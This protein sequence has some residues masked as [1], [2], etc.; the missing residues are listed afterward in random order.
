ME[1]SFEANTDYKSKCF[2]KACLV[3]LGAELNVDYMISGSFD[4]LGRKIVITLKLID[5]KNNVVAKSA[6]HEFNYQENEL[7]RM[8]EIIIR[9][10]HGLEVQK[11]LYE[12][13]NFKNEL[14]TSTNL[15]KVN[16][17]V[18]RV[19]YGIFVRALEEFAARLENH[20]GMDI[21]P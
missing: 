7:Q 21:F 11:E 13:L 18:P 20:G 10:M 4:L 9:E 16:N 15:G 3:R 17:S 2:S 1:E 19:G 5:V 12:S 14:I 6:M 8:T